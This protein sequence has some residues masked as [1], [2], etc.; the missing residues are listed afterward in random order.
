VGTFSFVDTSSGN[1]EGTL[2]GVKETA[3]DLFRCRVKCRNTQ[4]KEK[5]DEKEVSRQG[6][7]PGK[8]EQKR[9]AQGEE[10]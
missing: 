7:H 9:R 5:R 2:G 10:L 3:L 8:V 4:Q 6:T 1:P